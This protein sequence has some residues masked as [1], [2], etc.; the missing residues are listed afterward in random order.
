MALTPS[1]LNTVGFP[2]TLT[3]FDM[4]ASRKRQSVVIAD[5]DSTGESLCI[6]L[7]AHDQPDRGS[8][9]KIGGYASAAAPAAVANGD[10]VNAWFTQHGALNTVVTHDPATVYDIERRPVEFKWASYGG[11]AAN[12]I[13]TGVGG[14][15][16]K[17]VAVACAV[18]IYGSA[19][20]LYLWDG[21][22]A[23]Y[24]ARAVAVGQN[25]FFSNG[26]M[27]FYQT[28]VGANLAVVSDGGGTI[29]WSVTY[30]YG[31]I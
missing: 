7:P 27:M 14:W 9:L 13:V 8:P 26:G 1:Q 15:R 19:S 24:L 5:P 23:Y 25:F 20:T 17:V 4:P 6:E 22:A 31:Q 2:G 29:N 11:T 30:Y 12:T 3:T 28:G 10:R 18:A 16:I 21:G